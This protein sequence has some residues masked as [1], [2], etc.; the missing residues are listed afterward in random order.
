[1]LRRK[2]SHHYVAWLAMLAMAFIVVMPAISRVMPMTGAMPGMDVA[3]PHPVAGTQHPSTPDTPVDPTAKCG[4]CVLLHHN[5][6]LASSVMPHALAAVVGQT[7]PT[8]ARPGQAPLSPLL[9]AR[10]RGPPSM[11]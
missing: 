9:S 3:C 11:A 10:P 7:T 4:Y 5:P 8:F 2:A 6:G 1:M